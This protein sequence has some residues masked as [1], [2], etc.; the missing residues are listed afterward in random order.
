[1]AK[2]EFVGIDEYLEKLNKI[3]DKTTGLCKR[4]LY[5]GAAVLADAVRS[6]VQALPVTDRNTEPQQVLSYERD[7]LLAGLG[8]AKMKDDGGVVSTRVDFDGYNRLKSKTYPNGHPNSMIARAINSGTSKRP[9]NPFMNRATRAARAK[10]EAAMAARM[11][12][13]IEEIMK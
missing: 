1:M 12:A 2:I 6:E 7:G 3:G 8:I 13:D 10:A 4:A 5:D 9:K 11:D